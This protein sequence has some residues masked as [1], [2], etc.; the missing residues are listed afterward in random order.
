MSF[1]FD[2]PHCRYRMHEFGCTFSDRPAHWCPACGTLRTCE[3]FIA[4]PANAQRTPP[5]ADRTHGPHGPV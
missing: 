5:P 4:T 3:G 1:P 2:C